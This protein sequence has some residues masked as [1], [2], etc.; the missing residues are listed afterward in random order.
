[1]L[2]SAHS[3]PPRDRLML[4]KPFDQITADDIRDLCA[5]GA[6]ENQLLEFKRELPAERKRPD[7]W[8]TGGDFTAYARDR[9]FR[10]IVA[11]ANAQGGTLVLGIEETR[12]QPPRA[13][14]IY[15]LPRIHDLATRMEDAARAA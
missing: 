13:A 11:F 9:L 12:D 8:P 15:R 3:S 14:T 1:V 2:K 7:P 6:Y 4:A 10:E 5:R